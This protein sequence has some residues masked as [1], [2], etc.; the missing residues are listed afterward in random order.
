MLKTTNTRFVFL[1]SATL[2]ESLCMSYGINHLPP[3]PVSLVF[4]ACG[5][6]V[7]ILALLKPQHDFKP[8]PRYAFWIMLL[9][10]LLLLAAAI[11]GCSCCRCCYRCYSE[12]AVVEPA[13]AEVAVE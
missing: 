7:G 3:K 13:A 6:A 4:M 1:F 9:P 8:I 11:S 12:A 2:L 10:L 5:L